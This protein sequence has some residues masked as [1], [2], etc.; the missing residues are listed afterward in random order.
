MRNIGDWKIDSK[1]TA[2][3]IYIINAETNQSLAVSSN[4]EVIQEDFQKDKSQQ[5]WKKILSYGS[6]S[7]PVGKPNANSFFRLRNYEN[8][9]EILTGPI[10]TLTSRKKLWVLRGNISLTPYLSV[11]DFLKS[12]FLEIDF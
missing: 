3:Y 1:T 2:N 12:L 10:L 9:N 11:L 4:G 8:I 6:D 7:K 5:L